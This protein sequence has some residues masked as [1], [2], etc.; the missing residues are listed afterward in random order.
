[1]EFQLPEKVKNE[2][3]LDVSLLFVVLSHRLRIGKYNMM[4]RLKDD[5]AF[6]M[7]IEEVR[8]RIEVLSKG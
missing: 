1:M 2:T 5:T 4:S 8:E 3:F 7:Q 6:S